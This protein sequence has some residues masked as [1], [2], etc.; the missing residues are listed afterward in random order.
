MHGVFFWL[1]ILQDEI[2]QPTLMFTSFLRNPA[3]EGLTD[4]KWEHDFVFILHNFSGNSSISYD[5]NSSGFFQT[6]LKYLEKNNGTR[7]SVF[8]RPSH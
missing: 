5:Y 1:W 6:L 8:W 4:F 7:K 2:K 3:Y